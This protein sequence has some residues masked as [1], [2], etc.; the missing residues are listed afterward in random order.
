[1]NIK[2]QHG[3]QQLKK[4][5]KLDRL[6]TIAAGKRANGTAVKKNIISVTTTTLMSED[7]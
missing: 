6:Q 5:R 1:M 2:H 4:G 7:W 3:H